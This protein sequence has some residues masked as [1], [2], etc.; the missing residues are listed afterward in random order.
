V[1]SGRVDWHCEEL[2]P[3]KGGGALA[4]STLYKGV[5][6]FVVRMQ[7]S[8][9][10]EATNGMFGDPCEGTYKYLTVN[11]QVLL[12]HGELLGELD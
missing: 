5:V 6:I 2:V 11:Y 1:S 9:T 7:D 3:R 10:I 12:D 8:C 4:L